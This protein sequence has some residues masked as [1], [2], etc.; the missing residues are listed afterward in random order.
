MNLE[1]I[2]NQL[3]EVRAEEFK[4]AFQFSKKEEQEALLN[5]GLDAFTQYSLIMATQGSCSANGLSD[6]VLVSLIDYIKKNN[7]TSSKVSK[8]IELVT[9]QNVK[10]EEL[11]KYIQN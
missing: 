6:R 10:I 8:I 3:G 11:D 9:T 5:S 4:M 2:L 1:D 7:L